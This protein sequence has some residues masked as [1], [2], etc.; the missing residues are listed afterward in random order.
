MKLKKLP[1]KPNNGY[2]G[3]KKTTVMMQSL[4]DDEY[5]Y[6]LIIYKDPTHSLN[7]FPWEKQSDGNK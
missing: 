1:Y 4:Y 5:V 2:E 7:C 3:I 6:F